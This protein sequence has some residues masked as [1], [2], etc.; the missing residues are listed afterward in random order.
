MKWLAEVNITKIAW[1]SDQFKVASKLSNHHIHFANQKMKIKLAAQVLSAS[2]ADAIEFCD[3]DLNTSE[4][5]KS[6]ATV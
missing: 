3:L 6:E 4:F 2:D 5:K 1:I